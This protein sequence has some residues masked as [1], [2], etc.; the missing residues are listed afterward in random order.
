MCIAGTSS[1][2]LNYFDKAAFDTLPSVPLEDAAMMLYGSA[3][4]G[5]RPAF[6]VIHYLDELD[7]WD[8]S[9]PTNEP[10]IVPDA[11]AK[12]DPNYVPMITK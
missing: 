8:Y 9:I 7:L 5:Y 6:T 2:H 1:Y 11:P 12:D 10:T 3:R 4:M